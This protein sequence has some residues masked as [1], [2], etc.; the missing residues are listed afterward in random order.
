[1]ITSSSE[2]ARRLNAEVSNPL[3]VVIHDAETIL[4]EDSL[5][6]LFDFLQSYF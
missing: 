4:L 3:L 2:E 5:I 1:M 6:L